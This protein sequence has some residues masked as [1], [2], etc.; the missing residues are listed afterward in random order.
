MNANCILFRNVVLYSFVTIN[1]FFLISY[2][3]ANLSNLSK[4]LNLK[5]IGDQIFDRLTRMLF[6]MIFSVS[7]LQIEMNWQV[8]YLAAV[9]ANLFYF[10]YYKAKRTFRCS[11]SKLLQKRY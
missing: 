1:F 5:L 4:L 2:S 6:R 9:A 3:N 8:P 11:T 7:L 10:Y